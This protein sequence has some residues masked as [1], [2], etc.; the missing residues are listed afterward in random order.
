MSQFNVNRLWVFESAYETGTVLYKP[1]AG[2][3]AR[4]EPM[5]DLCVPDACVVVAE[6]ARMD[7]LERRHYRSGTLVSETEGALCMK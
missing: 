1:N 4:P 3:L 5:G 6:V 7:R 2:G